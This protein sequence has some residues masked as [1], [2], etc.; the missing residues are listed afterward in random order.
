M[1][2]SVSSAAYSIHTVDDC[3]C[4][5]LPRIDGAK[6][7]ILLLPE[8]YS[9]RVTKVILNMILLLKSAVPDTSGRPLGLNVIVVQPTGL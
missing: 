8:P 1:L 5:G 4:T 2:I 7:P 9:L 6:S 3:P